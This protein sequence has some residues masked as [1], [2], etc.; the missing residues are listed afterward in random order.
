[1]ACPLFRELGVCELRRELVGNRFLGV[2]VGLKRGTLEFVEQIAF[3]DFSAVR[4]VDLLE[5]GGHA[6]ED[7]DPIDRLDPADELVDLCQ[8]LLPRCDDADRGDARAGLGPGDPN[9]CGGRKEHEACSRRS[10]ESDPNL[11]DGSGKLAKA[12][13]QSASPTIVTLATSLMDH[14]YSPLSVSSAAAVFRKSVSFLELTVAEVCRET[15]SLDRKPRPRVICLDGKRYVGAHA[16][17]L[18][19][20]THFF[21]RK[22]DC[23][24]SA[25]PLRVVFESGRESPFGS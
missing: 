3:L 16:L 1:M 20:G 21:N 4:E 25:L 18:S 2:E 22:R 19:F 12:S 10:R 5:I 23:S 15:T 7:I 17:D 8:R 11:S 9:R 6:G 24:V 14:A 13:R